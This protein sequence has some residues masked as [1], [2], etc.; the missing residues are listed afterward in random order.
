[1][2]GQLT[3]RLPERLEMDVLGLAKKLHLKRSDIVRMALERL[4]QSEAE[5]TD[6]RPFERV[7]HLLGSVESGI[8]DLGSCH[9]ER[10]AERKKKV[11]MR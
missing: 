1:M 11:M 7:Q 9:R 6:D 10:L 2:G 3:I 8:A 5:E 4:V